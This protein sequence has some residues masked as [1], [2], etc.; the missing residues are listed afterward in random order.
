MVGQHPP[1][2]SWVDM[3]EEH[4]SLSAVV[5]CS[6]GEWRVSSAKNCCGGIGGG[7]E[8][9]ESSDSGEGMLNPH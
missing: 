9:S 3:V 5:H 6:F 7:G 4:R 2:L 8:S 1:G